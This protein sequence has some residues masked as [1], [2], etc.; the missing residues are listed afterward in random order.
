MDTPL[1]VQQ[2]QPLLLQILPVCLFSLTKSDQKSL[3]LQP[4]PT[5][6]RFRRLHLCKYRNHGGGISSTH[7]CSSQN[8]PTIPT[9]NPH[10]TRYQ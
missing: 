9:L 7:T 6:S 8:T 5:L 4:I 1:S 3:S 2:R 10:L